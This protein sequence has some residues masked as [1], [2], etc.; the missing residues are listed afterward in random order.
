MAFRV[1]SGEVVR[2][3]RFGPSNDLRL[4]RIPFLKKTDHSAWDRT[5]IT[6]HPYGTCNTVQL[7]R[8]EIDFDV[9]RL[10]IRVNGDCGRGAHVNRRRK[11]GSAEEALAFNALFSA[12]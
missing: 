12:V 11:I 5:A 6:R 1:R 3:Y 8:G 2:R 4:D 7:T 9:G 10:A